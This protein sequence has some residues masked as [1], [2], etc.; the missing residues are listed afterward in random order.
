MATLSGSVYIDGI[1]IGSVTGTYVDDSVEQQSETINNVTINITVYIDSTVIGSGLLQYQDYVAYD[2]GGSRRIDVTGDALL[3]STVVGSA[4]G[5][6]ID[7]YS[8]VVSQPPTPPPTPTPAPTPTTSTYYALAV[9]FVLLL[10]LLA[11][12]RRR[13]QTY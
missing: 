2:N 11:V 8:A 1:V 9:L 5:Y 4:V 7:N 10:L 13:S 3:D 12:S 6:L